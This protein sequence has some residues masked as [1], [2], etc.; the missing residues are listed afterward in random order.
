MHFLRHAC[1]H[2]WH[3]NHVPKWA[4]LSRW[5]EAF[6]AAHGRKPRLWLDKASPQII[7]HPIKRDAVEGFALYTESKCEPIFYCVFVMRYR[8]LLVT[9]GIL[10]S[11]S[12]R[13]RPDSARPANLKSRAFRGASTNPTSP[14]TGGQHTF[15]RHEYIFLHRGEISLQRKFRCR[16]GRSSMTCVFVSW[17]LNARENLKSL[18]IFLSGCNTLLVLPGPTYSTRLWYSPGTLH[19]QPT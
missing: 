3:D 1:R 4:A 13:G 12:E 2:S 15:Q 5:C 16:V 14:R 10:L 6:E 19:A 11:E 18:P 8:A 9:I 7:A 17:K